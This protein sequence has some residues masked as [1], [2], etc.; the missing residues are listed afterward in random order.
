MA[1]ACVGVMTGCAKG[2]KEN[3]VPA[4]DDEMFAD[5]DDFDDELDDFDDYYEEDDYYIEEEEP[6]D[7][8]TDEKDKK[9]QDRSVAAGT[10]Y[11]QDY[12][13]ESNWAGSYKI[14]LKP[15]GKAS[16]TGWRNKDTG[17][18]EITGDN[19]ALITFDHCEKDDPDA[20][21][22]LVEGFKYTI[23]MTINGDSAQIR[24]DAPDIISNLEDGTV[25]RKG[26]SEKSEEA[27][28]SEEYDGERTEV[29]DG[30]YLTGEKYK[31]KLTLDNDDYATLTIKTA[32]YHEDENWNTVLDYEEQE[33]VFPTS[34]NCDCIIYQEDKEV[35]KIKDKVDFI[36]EFLE[37][38]SGLPIT[39][40]IVNDK[41]QEIS[42]SS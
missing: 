3:N 1:I 23:K 21:F 24:I 12:D 10:W 19:E 31:G 11:T 37:G 13:E 7:E 27:G 20:G 42:F 33:F 2:V 6:V 8:E 17:T 38:K 30:T 26:G 4:P 29:D 25:N 36:N 14:E 22:R 9:D 34:I 5:Y 39:L 35:Y 41:L 32:L 40:K 16:C 18:Y 15:D 28:K